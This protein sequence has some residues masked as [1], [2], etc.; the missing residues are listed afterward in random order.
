MKE[1]YTLD[2]NVLRRDGLVSS[3]GRIETVKRNYKYLN[4]SKNKTVVNDDLQ[5]LHK[6][7][8]R[9]ETEMNRLHEK[10]SDQAIMEYNLSFGKVEKKR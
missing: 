3:Y 2:G 10:F 7:K 6:Q 9:L 4:V 5:Q 1:I 8:I